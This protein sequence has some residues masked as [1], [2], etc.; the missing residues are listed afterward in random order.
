MDGLDPARLR[1][2][3]LEIP[4]MAGQALTRGRERIR[5]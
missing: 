1:R 4:E 3:K 2:A 5:G